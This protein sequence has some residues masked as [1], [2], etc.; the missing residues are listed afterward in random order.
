MPLGHFRQF[1]FSLRRPEIGNTHF[2]EVEDLE[3]RCPNSR[4]MCSF[5]AHNSTFSIFTA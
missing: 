5:M 3:T 2:A 1:H 4:A